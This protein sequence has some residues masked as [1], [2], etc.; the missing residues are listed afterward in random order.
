MLMDTRSMIP[1]RGVA[2]STPSVP[3]FCSGSFF[4]SATASTKCIIPPAASSAPVLQTA[5]T[6]VNHAHEAHASKK[7]P[8]QGWNRPCNLSIER[9][10]DWASNGWWQVPGRELRSS[11]PSAEDFCAIVD[12]K[13]PHRA[14]TMEAALQSWRPRRV[15]RG[16][17]R[18]LQ[19]EM[20]WMLGI[21]RDQFSC[22]FMFSLLRVVAASW[23]GIPSSCWALE[24]RLG[25]EEI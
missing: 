16:S 9:F 21:G 19:T 11:S 25:Q 23:L 20:F 2:S 14:P 4:V 18:L 3:A 17:G 24:C 13:P 22:F 15:S 1:A 6:V 10:T 7:L 8:K 5:Q 12:K